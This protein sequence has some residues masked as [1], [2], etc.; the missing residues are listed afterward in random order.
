MAF[1][2]N[3]KSFLEKTFD[4]SKEFLNKA[5]ARRRPGARWAGSESKS[6]GSARKPS[7]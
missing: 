7:P 1:S 5:G 3:L 2:D 6:F 4:G